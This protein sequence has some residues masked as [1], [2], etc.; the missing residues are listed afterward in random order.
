MR[1][2]LMLNLCFPLFP[3][4][5][6]GCGYHYFA[7][8]LIPQSETIQAA[9]MVV[10]DDRS[11][12]YVHERL[13]ISLRPVTD[14]ELNR[15]WPEASNM[16]LKSTNPYTYG[17]WKDPV[18][19]HTPRRF[20]VFL[21]KVKNYTYPK[22]QVDPAKVKI[23]SQ[24]GREYSSLSMLELEEYYYPYVRGYAGVAHNR[25]EARKDILRATLYAGDVIFS[26]QESEGYVV[27]PQLHPDVRE[28]AVFINDVVL[29]FNILDEPVETTDLVS[30][31]HRDVYKARQPRS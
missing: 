17:N 13:E 31:F 22:V 14:E 8:D 20:S 25:F 7:G 3:L 4:F 5:I 23:V 1:T 29:R 11:V 18:T 24:N 26:G 27:F 2:K 6:V 19:N 21:L 15:N 16:G 30:R 28:I 10:R 9:K 12:A